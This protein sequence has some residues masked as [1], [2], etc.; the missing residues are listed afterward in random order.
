MPAVTDP[1]G[2]RPYQREALEAVA[3]RWDAGERRTWIVLP[4]GA[5]KTLVGLA[6]ARRLDRRTVVLV[7]N[8][9]IQGQWIRTWDSLRS[10]GDDRTAGTDRDLSHH[11]T[12]LTYQSLAVFDPDTETDEEGGGRTSVRDRLHPNG[13]ALVDALHGAGPLTVLLDECHH[14]LQ[15]WGR[16][17][18]EVLDELP[19]AHVI[20]LT[21]TPATDLTAA[22]RALVDRLFGEPV[23]GA[24]IP[25]LVRD[26]YL[27]PFAELVYLTA[28]TPTELAYLKD[29]GER[30]SRMC[31]ELLTPGFATTDLLPWIDARFVHRDAAE[32]GRVPWARVAAA[33][34]ALAD[35]VLRLHHTG[36]CDLPEGARPLE[37]H[38]RPPTAADWIALIDDYARRCL[39]P[40][41][42]SERDR[43]ARERLRASLPAIGHHLTRNGVRRGVSPVDRVLA[44]SDSK[45]HATAEILA[46]EAAA[47]GE[48]LRALV[49]CDH[50]HA[51]SRPPVALRGILDADAG[52]AR[53]QL[54]TLAGDPRT[55]LLD[56]VLLT[57]RTVA[58]APGTAMLFLEYARTELPGADLAAVDRPDGLC[59]IVG[60]WSP[61]VRV[62]AVTR[63]FESGGSRVLVG[64]RALLGE[65]W[66]ARGVNT[67]VD[68]TTA[69]TPTAVVQSRGRALRLDPD[70]PDKTAHTWTVVC[71]SGE[72]PR[73]DADWDR[74]V[75]KHQGYLGVDADG[76]VMGG[77]AHIDPSLSPYAPPADPEE[78][79]RRMLARVGRRDLTRERWR[80]G[81]PYEDFLLPT[82]RVRGRRTP[83]V[84][85]A[86]VALPDPPRVLPGR[87]GVC[88]AG[89]GPSDPLPGGFPV[90]AL[91]LSA[92][93]A[94]LVL[95][96][97][98][99][100]PWSLLAAAATAALVPVALRVRGAARLRRARELLAEA[101]EPDDAVR[102]ACAVAEALRGTGRST[103]GAAGVR[104]RVDT[105]GVYRFTLSDAAEDFATSLEELVGPVVGE[106]GYVIPRPLPPA[107]TD[108]NARAL[109]DGTLPENPVVHHVVPALFCRNR[110]RLEAF[111]AAWGH[112]IAPTS[113]IRTSTEPGAALLA[114][115]YGAS[116][117]EGTSTAHRLTWS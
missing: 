45:A 104:V 75:R 47:L 79:N 89:T 99:A 95:F 68:L 101:A 30:F 46:A 71:V 82:L 37:E 91:L 5:G 69:T 42:A 111:E 21:G 107:A 64:T 61:R 6:A 86:D 115:H 113:A 108:A 27:A 1:P 85:G 78:L 84:R 54:T 90:A 117:L 10:G 96:S 12:V 16:L 40:D 67:V 60:P 65:G 102:Y 112:W 48:R 103:A 20:G 36:L 109:L 49:L 29:Q 25:A 57:G 72:H 70:R 17:L 97:A 23:T 11:T 74:F 98:I 32:G 28:P 22:E 83:A 24:S 55:D 14:L 93:T 33:E 7:P 63:F 73:G 15:V 43:R 38:R 76:E 110:T 31:D 51:S 106:P 66:D 58:M 94:L 53:L 18:A 19:D 8:T 9:A 81:E 39:P 26:G 87:R 114:A 62:G 56:P 13:R 100:S 35:A 34:P 44:R 2:L 4:P 80:I 92:L 52:S 3:A 41:T 88:P 116:P 105:D 50:E 59:D 77:V